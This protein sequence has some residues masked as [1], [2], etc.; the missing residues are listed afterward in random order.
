M[1]IIAEKPLARLNSAP[2]AALSNGLNLDDV[3]SNQ[4]ELDRT[5]QSYYTPPGGVLLESRATYRSTGSLCFVKKMQLNDVIISYCKFTNQPQHAMQ[6]KEQF[7][8]L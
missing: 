7:M 6:N 3:T 2:L 4:T 1:I 8:L 5:E